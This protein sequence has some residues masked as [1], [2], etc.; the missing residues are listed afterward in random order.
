MFKSAGRLAL[1]LLVATNGIVPIQLF[2]MG[3]EEEK[4]ENYEQS[5]SSKTP[6]SKGKERAHDEEPTNTLDN[7]ENDGSFSSDE[8]DIKPSNT[9]SSSYHFNQNRPSLSHNTG[10]SKGNDSI[11]ATESSFLF[12][13]VDL[14]KTESKSILKKALAQQI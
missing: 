10:C 7:Q 11:P 4:M 1:S 6:L 9:A 2:A 5:S 14:T 8:E 13:Q 3:G 12:Q